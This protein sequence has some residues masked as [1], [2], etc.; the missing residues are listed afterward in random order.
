MTAKNAFV[1]CGYCKALVMQAADVSLHGEFLV[2]ANATNNATMSLSSQALHKLG[3]SFLRELRY[4]PTRSR[5]LKDEDR[6]G[7]W[8]EEREM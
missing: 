7:E 5:E 8:K 3:L 6:R 1:L 4:A 2:S